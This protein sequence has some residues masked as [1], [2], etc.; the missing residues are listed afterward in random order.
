MAAEACPLDLSLRLGGGATTTRSEATVP[1]RATLRAKKE[2]REEAEKAKKEELA[3][4]PFAERE[5]RIV[6]DAAKEK[7]AEV[8]AKAQAKVDKV[9]VA[10][11]GGGKGKDKGK[12]KKKSKKG[13]GKAKDANGNQ[14]ALAD[15]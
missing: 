8:A 6:A 4:L 11:D 3:A 14:L 2:T 13:G 1:W 7:A 15:E 9:E 12:G 10:P 5:A